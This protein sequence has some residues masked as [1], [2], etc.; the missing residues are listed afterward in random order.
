MDEFKACFEGGKYRDKIREDEANAR[1]AGIDGTPTFLINGE[2]VRGDQP[3]DVFKEV[4]ESKLK[5]SESQ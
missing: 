1:A 3:Y 2:V 4:I 5:E